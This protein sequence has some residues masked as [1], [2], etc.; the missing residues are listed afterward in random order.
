MIDERLLRPAVDESVVTME[1]GDF[2]ILKKSPCALGQAIRRAQ[3]HFPDAEIEAALNRLS[4][5]VLLTI[6]DDDL[7]FLNAAMIADVMS[8][9]P[10]ERSTE[11]S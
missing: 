9:G 7:V 8:G 4:K 3:C 6:V 2:E 10:V 5:T 11:T 1:A